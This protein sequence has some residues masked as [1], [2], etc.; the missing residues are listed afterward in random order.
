MCGG[1]LSQEISSEPD[2]VQVRIRNLRENGAD[3]A[4]RQSSFGCV[5]CVGEGSTL[6]FDRALKSFASV[7]EEVFR[8][9]SER[10][11]IAAQNVADT[12]NDLSVIDE[13]NASELRGLDPD[14]AL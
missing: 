6:P 2:V 10:G 5:T 9:A 7:A 11:V 14:F 12:I 3:L 4:A 1:P 8:V 13:E